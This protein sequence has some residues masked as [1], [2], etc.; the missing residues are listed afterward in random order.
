[1]ETFECL[2]LGAFDFVAKPEGTVSAN[3]DTV[4]QELIT[5]IR[6]AASGVSSE[7]TNNPAA[8]GGGADCEPGAGGD[9][10]IA[11]G[12][13]PVVGDHQ[14]LPP[15]CPGRHPRCDL[16]VQHMPAAHRHLCLRLQKEWPIEVVE[17]ETGTT[18]RPG[19]AT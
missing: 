14:T 4:A 15:G 9:S 5:K 16:L 12:S 6:A 17:A 10:A 18:V 7:A 3:L 1:V 19:F 2:A 8:T 11:I 13:R